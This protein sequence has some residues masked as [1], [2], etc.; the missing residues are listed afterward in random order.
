MK[1][2]RFPRH[3]IL[4][5]LSAHHARHFSRPL[6]TP[7]GTPVPVDV[8]PVPE[9][10]NAGYAFTLPSEILVLFPRVKLGS[11]VCVKERWRVGSWKAG[12]I[13]VD[14]AADGY[15]RP[16]WL[17]VQEPFL[18][19][20]IR[21][22]CDDL[23]RAGY[24][25]DDTGRYTWAFGQAP[26]RTR[27]P[28]TM[29]ISMSRAA[30]LITRVQPVRLS[31]LT[32]DDGIDAGMLSVSDGWCQEHFPD[33]WAQWQHI[34]RENAARSASGHPGP[35]PR[36]L[37][38]PTG[39]TPQQR[40]LTALRHDQDLKPGQ[41]AWVWATDVQLLE[42]TPLAIYQRGQAGLRA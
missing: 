31:D 18:S 28:D 38:P 5:L 20:I 22:S 4:Q 8:T 36:L 33:W 6:L 27:R 34:S 2:L 30:G 23:D 9:P 29:R 37:Q 7:D 13:A 14:Y 21:E 40:L 19:Q 32:N 1:S 39:P 41:D 3:L 11:T 24:V 25:P 15:A 35:G 12:H 26:T 10:D 16:E 17:P 42:E